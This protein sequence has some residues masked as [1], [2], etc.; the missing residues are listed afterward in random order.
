MILIHTDS[1]FY[2]KYKTA[3]KKKCAFLQRG[4]LP[5]VFSLKMKKTVFAFVNLYVIMN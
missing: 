4:E 3:E 5:T 2:L 1:L